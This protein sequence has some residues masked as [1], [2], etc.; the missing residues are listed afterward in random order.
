MADKRVFDNPFEDFVPHRETS[1]FSLRDGKVF[2]NC[3][4]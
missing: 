1:I 2:T 4:I 3:I